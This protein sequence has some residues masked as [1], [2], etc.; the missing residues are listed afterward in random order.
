MRYLVNGEETTLKMKYL[1][2]S[3]H[4]LYTLLQAL[5]FEFKL[6]TS[7][8]IAITRPRFHS[9]DASLLP[10]PH[11]QISTMKSFVSSL[12][13][14]GTTITSSS[15][16]AETPPQSP[17]TIPELPATPYAGH[18]ETTPTPMETPITAAGSSGSLSSSH[19][20]SL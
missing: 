18:A 2:S 14:L 8:S 1:A 9:T 16:L 6:N 15:S 3:R 17:A 13:T 12:L 10:L 5:S 7:L 4:S 19:S 11:P 20:P